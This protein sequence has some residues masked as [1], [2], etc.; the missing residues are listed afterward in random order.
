MGARSGKVWLVGAGP[1]DP[2]LLTL[3]AVE[4]LREAHVVLVDALVS[5]DV[6]VYAREGARVID[7]GKRAGKH[8]ATQERINDL[9]IAYAER[10]LTVVRL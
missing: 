1:G 5:R 2:K 8:E 6:L 10:G 3:R 4:V 7:V 9:L